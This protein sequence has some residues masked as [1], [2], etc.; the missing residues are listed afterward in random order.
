MSSSHTEFSGKAEQIGHRRLSA[1]LLD[2]AFPTPDVVNREAFKRQIDH[3]GSMTRP[4]IGLFIQRS[5]HT[6]MALARNAIT[7]G[8]TGGQ[9]NGGLPVDRTCNVG[10]DSSALVVV[11]LSIY[12]SRKQKAS[13]KARAG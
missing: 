7:E 9:I 8:P 11:F 13:V 12:A 6:P 2:E 10:Y 5:S 3:D 1:K 4:V